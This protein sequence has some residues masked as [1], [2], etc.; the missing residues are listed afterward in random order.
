[1]LPLRPTGGRRMV[2]PCS[3]QCRRHESS[4][5]NATAYIALK[6]RSKDRDSS[7][8]PPSASHIWTPPARKGWSADAMSNS[9]AVIYPACLS[10]IR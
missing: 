8:P 4:P 6:S 3:E 10:G 2:S 7:N 9:V 1:M 5:Q